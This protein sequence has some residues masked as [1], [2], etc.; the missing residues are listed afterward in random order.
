MVTMTIVALKSSPNLFHFSC[1]H[2]TPVVYRPVSSQVTGAYI[3]ALEST[4]TPSVLALSRQNCVHL[5]GSSPE[6][7]SK[8]AYTLCE[9]GPGSSPAIILAGTGTSYLLALRLLCSYSKCSNIISVPSKS[10]TFDH[11]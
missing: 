9:H 2:L 8:G 1:V 3:C 10:S 11:E 4:G 6:A 5:E 7:V